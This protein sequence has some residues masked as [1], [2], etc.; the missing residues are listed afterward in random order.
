MRLPIPG[1]RH[2]PIGR[3]I[4]ELPE[5]PLALLYRDSHSGF[6]AFVP[7]GSIAAG[8]SLVAMKSTSGLPPCATC[9]GVRL[10]G[11]VAAPPLAGRPATYLVRQLWAFKT[12]KRNPPQAA[13]MRLVAAPLTADQMLSMAAYLAS[14][15]PQ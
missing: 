5:D 11:S 14:L 9:H 3:R 1:G 15:P 6:V 13:A 4:V 12:G 10:T 8:R 2:E 7:R